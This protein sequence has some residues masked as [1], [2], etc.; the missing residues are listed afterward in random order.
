MG[1]Q[2]DPNKEPLRSKKSGSP[3]LILFAAVILLAA[4]GIAYF[5]VTHDRLPTT[6]EIKDKA[7]ELAGKS[8][9]T[10][11]D[12][13]GKAKEI[14]KSCPIELQT[15]S[16]ENS[17]TI[18]VRLK[19]GAADDYKSRYEKI[20]VVIPQL[21]FDSTA[22]RSDWPLIGRKTAL[23]NRTTKLEDCPCTVTGIAADGRAVELYRQ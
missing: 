3:L 2:A 16:A 13:A 1:K 10:A 17:T 4:T 15:T 21:D 11:T 5:Y 7:A 20:R 22:S 23:A 18:V 14:A 19:P 8:K 12:L 9:E 6:G